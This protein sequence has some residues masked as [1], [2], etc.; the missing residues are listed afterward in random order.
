[1]EILL[2]LLTIVVLGSTAVTL[3][4]RSKITKA[5]AA[6]PTP[7]REVMDTPKPHHQLSR[8]WIVATKSGHMPAGWRWRCR[9]GAEG[10]AS[11]S[12]SREDKDGMI[13]YSLGTEES[14]VTGFKAH[15]RLHKEASTDVYKDKFEAL[16]EEF[17]QYRDKCYCKETNLD[18]LPWKDQ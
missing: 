12:Y 2:I 15:A 11:N 13:A 6:A 1:M 16:T 3:R 7:I 4:E 5:L 10:I 9:C 18:L 14:A 8:T 17:A